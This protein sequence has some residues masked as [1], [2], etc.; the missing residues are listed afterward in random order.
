MIYHNFQ[1][2]Y[3]FGRIAEFDLQPK[4]EEEIRRLAGGILPLQYLEQLTEE[5]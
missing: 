1:I 5:G 4:L 2:K 3:E